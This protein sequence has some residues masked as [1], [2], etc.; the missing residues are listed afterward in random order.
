MR[1]FI[2]IALLIIAVLC[3]SC[4]RKEIKPHKQELTH[5]TI[6]Y[7]NDYH[8]HIMPFKA[9]F[10]DEHLVGGMARIAT[11]VNGIKRE[12]G[13]KGIPTLFLCAGDVLQGTPMSTVFKGEPDFRCL[14]EIGLNA[15]VLGNHEFDY[16]QENLNKLREMAQFAILGANVLS[17]RGQAPIVKSYYTRNIHGIKVHILG[18]VTDETPITTHPRNVKG[19]VFDDPITTAQGILEELDTNDLI[20]ALTHLGYET[21]KKLAKCAQGI[22]IIIGGHSHTKL[23]RPVKLENTIICQA[24]EYGEFIGRLDLDIENGEIALVTGTLIPVTEDVEEDSAIKQIVDEYAEKLDESLKQVI[25]TAVV[26]LNGEREAVR[27]EETN[28]GN[29]IADVMR[30][31]GNADVA[32]I[33]GGGI[34]AGIDQGDIT[35]E[36]VLTVLPYENH[37]VTLRL[38]GAEILTIMNRHAGLEPG[39]GAFLQVSGLRVEI[40]NGKIA[41]LSIGG[42]Q[43][44]MEKPYAIATNDFLA[45]GGDGYETFKNGKDYVDTGLLVS[46]IVIDYIKTNREIDAKTEGRITEN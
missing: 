28:L 15:M 42:E 3:A 33:N 40:S 41:M 17:E 6:L 12:N 19:L 18:L 36:E 14:N 38:K 5:L 9:H 46:D 44:E 10:N 2:L 8:G 37:L 21:D 31:M 11:I 25:G 32:F 29:L 34:R 24:Y 43:V 23:E 20:I 39:D 1:R 22:D 4:A 30:D 16:G 26:P 13:E 35:V 7:F 27:N 45:A